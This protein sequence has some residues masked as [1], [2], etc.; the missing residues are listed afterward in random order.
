M[1]F[2]SS[3]VQLEL[4]ESRI[5]GCC[6]RPPLHHPGWDSIIWLFPLPQQKYLG[7]FSVLIT[8]NTF[9]PPHFSLIMAQYHCEKKFSCF[10]CHLVPPH[11]P[12]P[13]WMSISPQIL[14]S[15]ATGLPQFNLNFSTTRRTCK[16]HQVS[17][18]AVLG[19]VTENVTQK[20]SL[21]P[22]HPGFASHSHSVPP[23]GVLQVN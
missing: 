18:G 2:E 10:Q 7:N 6:P 3:W 17:S 15:V 19:S 1:L 12:Q 13:S 8:I 5:N 16:W 4:C 14:S 21:P 11:C 9:F 20:L 23:S 22:L